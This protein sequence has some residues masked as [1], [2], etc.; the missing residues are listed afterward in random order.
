MSGCGLSF[1]QTNSRREAVGDRAAVGERAADG[2][3]TAVVESVVEPVVVPLVVDHVA[4]D[5]CELEYHDTRIV[6]VAAA[7]HV[8]QV[9]PVSL[10]PSVPPSAVPL[11]VD[12]L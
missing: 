12:Y 7:I 4:A 10:S 9:L 11:V 5:H 2:E 8:E 1:S 6:A 3:R